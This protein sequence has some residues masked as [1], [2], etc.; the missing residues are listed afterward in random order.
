[1]ELSFN[2]WG[3]CNPP[4][5]PPPQAKTAKYQIECC[6]GILLSKYEY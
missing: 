2:I 6:F 1:M 4:T 5:P 3:T